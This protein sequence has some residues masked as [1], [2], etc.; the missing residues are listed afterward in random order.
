MKYINDI[1]DVDISIT[2]P[3]ASVQS[4][5]NLC[6]IGEAPADAG[7]GTAKIG[8]GVA[9]I[10]EVDDLTQ[11]GYTSKDPIY[12]A[13][14]VALSQSP[15]P[16]R[17][18]IGVQQDGETI[19]TCLTRVSNASEW[20]GFSLAGLDTSVYADASTWAETNRKLFGF[21]YDTEESPVTVE[22]K[23]YTFGIYSGQTGDETRSEGNKYEAIALMAKCF[24]YEPGS[25]TWEFKTLNGVSVSKNL[26]SDTVNTLNEL[27]IMYYIQVANRKITRNSKVGSGEWIDTIRLKDYLI[28]E[29]ENAVL[30]FLASNVK[31]P[32][33]DDGITGIKNAIAGVLSAE[34]KNGGIDSDK[35]NDDGTVDYGYTVNVPNAVDIPKVDKRERKLYKVTFTAKLTGAIHFVRIRGTL[36]YDGTN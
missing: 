36:V 22:G 33:N 35:Y 4:Y 21:S 1:V 30:G 29:I 11:Y 8:D 15:C 7:S 3:V 10:T 31:V 34:Q 32:Y 18:F 5:S 24:G 17:I 12:N 25:E 14:S 26:S 19:S 27:P 16:S 23:D 20:Y 2:N 28:S 9:E 13:V 6:I